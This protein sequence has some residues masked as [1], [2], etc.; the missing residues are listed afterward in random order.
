MKLFP[1]LIVVCTLFLSGCDRIENSNLTHGSRKYLDL[2]EGDWIP[3]FIPSDAR[4]IHEVHDFDLNV[5]LIRYRSKTGI[6]AGTR[7]QPA[8]FGK[9]PAPAIGLRED[10]TEPV[11]HAHKDAEALNKRY[12]FSIAVVGEHRWFIARDRESDLVYI[13][14]R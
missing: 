1:W 6:A 3:P 5:G 4:E 2:V 13:W 11:F 10:L 7:L 8:E 12:E 14:N 9:L